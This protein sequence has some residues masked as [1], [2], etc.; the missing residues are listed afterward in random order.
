[1]LG[2]ETEQL[3]VDGA[4]LLRSWLPELENLTVEGVGHL[5]QIQRPEPVARGIAEFFG[6]HPIA[7][8]STW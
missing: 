1:V 6:R 3:F 2:A 7:T 8:R 4:S 5:L